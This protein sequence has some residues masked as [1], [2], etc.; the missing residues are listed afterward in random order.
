MESAS[1]HQLITIANVFLVA[2]LCT[3]YFLIARFFGRLNKIRTLALLFIVPALLFG[4]ASARYVFLNALSDP[5]ADVLA[6]TG[7][8]LLIG[9]S[10]HLFNTMTAGDN[11]T[12]DR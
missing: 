9:L 12:G 4:F 2:I 11:G 6:G 7:G 10:V 1:V 8:V 5:L 3:I